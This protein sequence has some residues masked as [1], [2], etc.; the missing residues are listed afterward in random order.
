MIGVKNN[1]GRS[2]IEQTYRRLVEDISAEKFKPGERMPGDRELAKEYGIGRSSMIQVL[3]RLQEERY[4][5]RIPVYGTFVR[6]DLHSRYQVVSLAFA[7]PDMSIS[8]EH[9]GLSGWGGVMELLRGIFEECSARPGIRTTILYCQDTADPH[10]LRTQL[11]EL[12]RF[13][14]VVFCGHLM[15]ALKQQYAAEAKPAVVVAPKPWEFPEIYPIVCFE[16]HDSLIGMA[17]YVMEQARGQRIVL[18]HWQPLRVDYQQS[19]NEVRTIVDE[20]RRNNAAYEEIYIDRL[21]TKDDEALTALEPLFSD[22]KNFDGKV[23]WCLNRRMLPVLNYLMQKYQVAS[24]LFGAT[25][26]VAQANIFP[27]VPYL[28]EPF[29]EMGRTAVQLLAGKICSGEPVGSRTLEPSLYCGS[30]PLQDKN[31]NRRRSS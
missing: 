6:N 16:P 7:T 22:R 17:R 3:S 31:Q 26:S 2:V 4:V 10:K 25:S 23:V 30:V 1:P 19:R 5:E 13:D 28:L 9:I 8:P 27:P 21:I 14:G 18:L 15:Q 20:L 24:P 29:Y 11:E 12:R